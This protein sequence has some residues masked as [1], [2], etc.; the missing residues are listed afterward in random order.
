MQQQTN[1]APT[2]YAPENLNGKRVVVTGG[3]NGIGRAVAQMLASRGAQIFTFGRVEEE[4]NAVRD[5]DGIPAVIADQSTLDGVQSAFESADAVLGGVDILVNCVGVSAGSVLKESP[6]H[7]VYAVNTNLTGFMLCTRAA[8]ERMKTNTG[9]LRG[10]IVM[11]G[12]IDTLQR[13]VNSDIHSATKAG[14]EAFA[15]S[16]RKTLVHPDYEV[17]GIKVSLIEPGRTQSGMIAPP[18]ASQQ[19]ERGEL[20]EARDVAGAVLYVLSQPARCDVVGVQIR[21]HLQM[22]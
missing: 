4:V 14:V 9:E 20:L 22:I 13:D 21:P 11:L 2:D 10:H 18:D 1:G 12:S 5:Q 16:L 3:T 8:I 6:E 15:A 19:I 7:V 17:P